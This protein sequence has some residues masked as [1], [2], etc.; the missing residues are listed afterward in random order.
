MNQRTIVGS[1]LLVALLGATIGACSS[2]DGGGDDPTTS[3]TTGIVIDGSGG[4]SSDAGGSS[5]SS[6]SGSS[7]GSGGTSQTTTSADGTSGGIGGSAGSPFLDPE[8]LCGGDC[9]CGNGIDDDDDGHIDG[10]D[11]E[12]TGIADNDEGTFA[13]GI[14]GD[15]KDPKWQDCFFDGNSGAG[16]DGCRYHTDC[17]SGDLPDNDPSCTVTQSC[18]DFCVE[19]T[20]SGCDCFGCCTF[21]TADGPLSVQIGITCNYEDIDDAAAC[22]RCEPSTQC[23][24]ECGECELCPGKEELPESCEEVPTC[25]DGRQACDAETPCPASYWCSLGCCILQPIE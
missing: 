19:R 17:L 24:N 5:S 3:G 14:S 1:Y 8:E 25:D 4:T 9:Q 21:E 18:I 6:D 15:N 16:D 20:P 2:D 22:P 7:D 12:C 11:T 13:T 23:G 10:F